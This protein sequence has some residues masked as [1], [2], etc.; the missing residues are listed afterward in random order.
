MIEYSLSCNLPAYLSFPWFYLPE[1]CFSGSAINPSCV[2]PCKQDE[3][4]REDNDHSKVS[5]RTTQETDV[6]TAV[7]MGGE[8]FV[9][10]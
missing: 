1:C 7:G 4:V 9:K 10:H 2:T 3:D 8:P 5:V 6:V